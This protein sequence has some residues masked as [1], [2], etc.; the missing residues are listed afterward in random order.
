[1]EKKIK[2]FIALIILC[3][4]VISACSKWDD[5]KKY[6]DE[7]KFYPQKPDSLNVYV[8]NERVLLEWTIVDPKV[9]SCKVYYTQEG[10][11]D[12]ILVPIDKYNNYA[13]DTIR[14]I[15]DNLIETTCYFKVISNDDSGH[16]SLA[17]EAEEYVYGENY[18]KSLLNR[19]L[20]SKHMYNNQCHLQWYD[21]DETELGIELNYKDISNNSKTIF[22]PDTVTSTVIDDFNVAYPFVYRTLYQP[23]STAIDTFYTS[24]EEV[25]FC[26][27]SELTNNQ[28]P[29]EITDKGWWM[30]NRAGTISG[31]IVN[32][33]VEKQGSVDSNWGKRMVMWGWSGYTPAPSIANGKIYQILS[34]TSGT[35]SFKATVFK[36]SSQD[37]QVY[38]VV[39]KGL[40]LLDIND[41][42]TEAL[43]FEDISSTFGGD[44]YVAI[45]EFTLEE[46]SIV[47]LGVIGNVGPNQEVFFHE[48]EL[49]TH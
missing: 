38:L 22:I 48:F 29:F 7:D 37:N 28:A 30:K 32:D 4:L 5:Y 27:P 13:K 14:V 44:Y 10:Q 26:F 9:T 8:G 19:S 25:I 16:S 21:A 12:S 20:K 15:I 49:I 43:S 23:R 33:I 17:V 18:R 42:E 36:M 3:P 41:I 35:Y 11:Q 47:S 40:S 46:P 45:C 24:I 2:W 31:W 39:N 34:L 6:I 1:M